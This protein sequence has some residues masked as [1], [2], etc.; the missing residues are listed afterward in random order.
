[1][2]R[3]PSNRKFFEER[4]MEKRQGTLSKGKDKFGLDF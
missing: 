2:D 4:A 3:Q 1:M